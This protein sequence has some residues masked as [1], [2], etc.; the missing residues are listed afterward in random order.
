MLD[1]NEVF[2]NFMTNRV[3]EGAK[4]SDVVYL[5]NLKLADSVDDERKVEVLSE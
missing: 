2:D 1:E 3:V 5:I 4:L